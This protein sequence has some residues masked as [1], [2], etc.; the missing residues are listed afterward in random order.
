LFRNF[1]FKDCLFCNPFWLIWNYKIVAM[2]VVHVYI[3]NHFPRSVREGT[4]QTFIIPSRNGPANYLDNFSETNSQ[5]R[6]RKHRQLHTAYYMLLL[7]L[8]L[9]KFTHLVP[10][11]L[12]RVRMLREI[13]NRVGM[14]FESFNQCF[15]IQLKMHKDLESNLS[16]TVV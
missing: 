10:V 14:L 8:S 5:S 7:F 4:R 1:I 12:F 2:L 13:K 15:L 16:Q 3:C 9:N 6:V 11:L